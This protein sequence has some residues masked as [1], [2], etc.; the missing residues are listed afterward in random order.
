MLKLIEGSCASFFPR[1]I[2]AMFRNRAETSR[3]GLAGRSW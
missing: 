1:E 2:D 3:I